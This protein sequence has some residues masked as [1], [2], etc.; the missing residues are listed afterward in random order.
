MIYNLTQQTYNDTYEYSDTHT[1]KTIIMYMDKPNHNTI[2]NYTT[3]HSR[4]PDPS[5]QIYLYDMYTMFV[6]VCGKSKWK[7]LAINV[8]M[9]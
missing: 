1:F 8:I 2:K 5:M 3:A 7:D 6:C 4:T 9:I